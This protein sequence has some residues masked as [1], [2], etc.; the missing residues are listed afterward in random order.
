MLKLVGVAQLAVVCSGIGSGLDYHL[1]PLHGVT[2]LRAM[3][4]AFHCHCLF[5]R[6]LLALY[7]FFR[8]RSLFTAFHTFFTSFRSLFHGRFTVF[9]CHSWRCCCFTAIAFWTAVCPNG[10]MVLQGLCQPSVVPPIVFP[11]RVSHKKSKGWVRSRVRAQSVG[12]ARAKFS[13]MRHSRTKLGSRW[14]TCSSGGAVRILRR[15]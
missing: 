6:P 15:S 13:S 9:H 14:C 4:I 8:F 7:G 12:P 11:P 2:L 1:T 10:Q 5:S 3:K